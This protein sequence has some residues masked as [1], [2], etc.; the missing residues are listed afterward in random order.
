MQKELSYLTPEGFTVFTSHYLK[1]K[2]T[3]CKSACLH[4]PY[5]FT[6]KKHGIQF[7]DVSE[8]DFDLVEEILKENESS[9]EW[10]TFWPENVKLV[11]LKERVAGLMLKNHI[12]VKHLLLRPHFQHQGI[13]KE[14]VESYFFI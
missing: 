3:C 12:V 4:C 8:N 9:V 13:S 6:I 5:G 14:L 11:L 2:G 1:N 7:R 10:K